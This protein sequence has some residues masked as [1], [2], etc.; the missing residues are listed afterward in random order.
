MANKRN[1]DSIVGNK[2]SGYLE[3]AAEQNPDIKELMTDTLPTLS[4][5]MRGTI[6]KGVEWYLQ[7]IWHP[8]KDIPQDENGKYILALTKY[9]GPQVI[10]VD[11]YTDRE[12]YEDFDD[13]E[14][15]EIIAEE[16]GIVKWCYVSDLLPYKNGK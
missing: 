16:E 7:D 1:I 8:G 15:W 10:D 9:E 3:A 2:L 11:E 13:E 4:A 6:V 12:E 14:T 5:L